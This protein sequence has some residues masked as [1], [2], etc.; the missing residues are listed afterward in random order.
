MAHRG[1]MI[2]LSYLL[3]LIPGVAWAQ[4]V[5]VAEPAELEFSTRVIFWTGAILVMG[6]VARVVFR[7]QLAERRTLRRLMDEIG[8]FFPEFD[9]DRLKRWVFACAPHVWDGW[10]R[11]DLSSIEGFVT[12]R[13]LADQQAVF[14]EQRRRGHEHA[15]RLDQVLKV[16]PL[17]MY[18]VGDGPPPRGV[19]LMLR[20]EQKA[21]DCVVQPDGAVIEG[22]AAPRQVMHFWALVHDGLRWRL[23]RVWPA[24]AGEDVDLRDRAPLPPVGEWQRPASE[25]G[26]ERVEAGDERVEPKPGGP[27]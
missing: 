7:E 16:H 5:D 13:F 1:I 25:A 23:D 24:R 20:L 6:L 21:I 9:I 19:E 27:L 11:R 2:R 14:D 10:R 12:A 4:A 8:P 22:S 3:F 15:A 26:D 18:A 17:G